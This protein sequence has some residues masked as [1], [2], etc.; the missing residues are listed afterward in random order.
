M[1]RKEKEKNR[2]FSRRK[3]VGFVE[4]ERNYTQK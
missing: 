1:K 3:R 2:L 4:K